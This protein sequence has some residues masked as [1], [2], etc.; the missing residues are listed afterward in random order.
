MSHSTGKQHLSCRGDGVSLT[1]PEVLCTSRAAPKGAHWGHCSSSPWQGHRPLQ[2]A[3]DPRQAVQGMCQPCFHCHGQSCP[4]RA[5]HSRT[6]TLHQ[7]H[8]GFILV[9]RAPTQRGWDPPGWSF[10]AGTALGTQPSRALSCS[11]PFEGVLSLSQGIVT[12]PC[13]HPS[14][15]GRRCSIHGDA[16]PILPNPPGRFTLGFMERQDCPGLPHSL[17]SMLL[18]A[19]SHAKVPDCHQGHPW[20]AQDSPGS[21]HPC[22]S[23]CSSS[24]ASPPQQQTQSKNNVCHLHSAN[25]SLK[26]SRSITYN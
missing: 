18:E 25:N 15:M 9:P 5:G 7:R 17:G 22:R 4:P 11:A 20:V 14:S 1:H 3:G 21:W 10:R 16:P 19:F 24:P 12:P 13:Q 2:V 6:P 23:L 8:P 26:I